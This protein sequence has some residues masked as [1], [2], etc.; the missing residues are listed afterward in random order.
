M[1]LERCGATLKVVAAELANHDR[2]GRRMPTSP[3]CS[4]TGATGVD[5]SGPGPA[6][7]A[8]GPVAGAAGVDAVPG[9]VLLLAALVGPA[10]VP[11][12]EAA[13]VA[14]PVLGLL[15]GALD[16][17]TTGGRLGRAGQSAL[18]FPAVADA[19]PRP[20]AAVRPFEEAFPAMAVSVLGSVL[21]LLCLK[22]Y[23]IYPRKKL[24]SWCMARHKIWMYF[25]SCEHVAAVK[26]IFSLSIGL[27]GGALG[28]SRV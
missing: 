10:A 3:C 25:Y 2:T 22:A 23:V 24:M 15:A 7:A 28:G 21:F 14:E 9:L 17:V 20:V 27:F 12:V 1:C 8:L 13:A 16:A 18:L 11:P 19:Q 4:R 26:A 5:A 6:A